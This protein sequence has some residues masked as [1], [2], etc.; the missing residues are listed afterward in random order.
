MKKL[1]ATLATVFTVSMFLSADVL[2]APRNAPTQTNPVCAA[3]AANAIFN[4]CTLTPEK[5]EITVF[6]MGLCRTHP[7]DDG[8]VTTTTMSQRDCTIFFQNTAGA[9]VDIVTFL[10]GNAA[11]DGTAIRPASGIYTYPYIIMSI[12][13][14][15]RGNVKG[16]PGTANDGVTFY[17]KA[18]GNPTNVAPSVDFTSNIDNFGNGALACFSGF[19]DEVAENGTIDAFLVNDAMVRADEAALLNEACT[20][21]TKVIGLM[22]LNTPFVITDKTRAINFMFNITGMGLG[23]RTDGNGAISRIQSGPFGGK[24]EAR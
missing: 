10:G 9:A 24:F 12:Q 18:D 6:E 21:I 23:I 14:T 22:Q 2:A 3:G 15:V 7:F 4:Y 16:V 13:V 11:L 1:I 20:G 8:V 17:S 5:Y 19:I